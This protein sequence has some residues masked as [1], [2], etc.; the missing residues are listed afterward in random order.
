MATRRAAKRTAKKPAKKSTK[1]A[2]ARTAKACSDG[3][4]KAFALCMRR[5]T[6]PAGRIACV[7]RLHVCLDR[8][9]D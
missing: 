3:C 5:A 7:R 4:V 6:T 1:A 8:C 2:D 9:D